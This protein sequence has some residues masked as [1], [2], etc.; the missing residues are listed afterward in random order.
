VAL[1]TQAHGTSVVSEAVFE[2]RFHH[3]KELGKFGADV[4]AEGRSAIIHGPA[5]LR[6]AHASVPDIRSGAALVI[7]ALCAEGTSELENIF[8][9][10]RGYEDLEQKL[11]AL[12]A[13]IE[14]IGSDAAGA[15]ARD[16]SAVV[17]D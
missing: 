2:N 10:Q 13:D 17:G 1:M 11:R 12:G 15:G 5:R 14:R 8:H 4:T 16:F 6:A 7:A 9:L 3:V